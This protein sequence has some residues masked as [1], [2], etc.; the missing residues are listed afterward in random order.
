MH[1][2]MQFWSYFAQLFLEWKMFQIKFV[3]KNKTHILRSVTVSKIV[4]F[5]R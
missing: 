2:N 3:E 4:P 5:M 1:T